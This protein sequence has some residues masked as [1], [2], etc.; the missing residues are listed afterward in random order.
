LWSFIFVIILLNK[1]NF[2]FFLL[3]P[4]ESKLVS[5]VWYIDS[6]YSIHGFGM[7]PTEPD[8]FFFLILILN[9]FN[10]FFLF[11]PLWFIFICFLQS[12]HGFKQISI[13]GLVLDSRVWHDSHRTWYVFFLRFWSSIYLI[14]FFIWSFMIY[15][16]LLS[17]KLSRSQT[18]IYFM[19]STW[20]FEYLFFLSYN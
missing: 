12:Y 1:K 14:D 20:F 15:F 4:M 13:L 18:N 8:M 6:G 17:T 19:V 3:I 7:I 16:Y 11:D 2:E 5:Q 10:W 9:L